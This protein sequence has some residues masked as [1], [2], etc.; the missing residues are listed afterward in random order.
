MIYECHKQIN[1]PIRMFSRLLSLSFPIRLIDHCRLFLFI[2]EKFY[3]FRLQLISRLI[4]SFKSKIHSLFIRH[5]L[6]L[7]QNQCGKKN[8]AGNLLFCRKKNENEILFI[9]FFESNHM[10]INGKSN[11]FRILISTIIIDEFSIGID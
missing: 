10:L 3:W 2:V 4:R 6:D 7:K 11:F 5:V 9:R 8:T 1:Q